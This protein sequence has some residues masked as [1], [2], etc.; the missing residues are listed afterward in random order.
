MTDEEAGLPAGPP[1]P[2]GAVVL[3][4]KA[5]RALAHPVRVQ[6]VGLLRTHGPSTATRLAER[7]GLTSGATSYH[8][9]QLAAAGFVAEDTERG[10]ARERWW[11]AVHRSTWFTDMGLADQEPEAALGYLQSIV[12]AH[13]QT[14]Q[15]AL[16]AL[17][18]MPRPW[19][20]VF[21]L[22]D[23]ALRLTP[24]EATRLGTELVELVG[25]YRQARPED[26]AAAPD[27]TRRVSV[28]VQLLPQ[29]TEGPGPAADPEAQAT[30]APAAGPPAP[31]DLR[32]DR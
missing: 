24:E 5:L 21:D 31:A 13:A 10:N 4:A 3:D 2:E 23:W 20:D 8:L 19:R 7:M 1:R 15:R 17:P 22:N 16:S 6:L 32:E 25:R 29:P 14:A 18:T 28:V 12:T 27:D 9:R 11:H 26:Q 30:P